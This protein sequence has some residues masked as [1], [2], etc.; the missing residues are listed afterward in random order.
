V[1]GA[2][3]VGRTVPRARA[4]DGARSERWPKKKDK[5]KDKKSKKKDKKSKKK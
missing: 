5:K 4:G 1:Q 2:A 3:R